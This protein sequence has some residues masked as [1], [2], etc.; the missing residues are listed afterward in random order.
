MD[1]NYKISIDYNLIKLERISGNDRIFTA[2]W[3]E[4]IEVTPKGYFSRSDDLSFQDFQV[5][6]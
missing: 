2:R 1:F 4:I 5:K 6:K 3:V